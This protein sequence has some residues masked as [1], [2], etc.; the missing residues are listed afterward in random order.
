M[1]SDAALEMTPCE[2]DDPAWEKD[3]DKR[4][5]PTSERTSF[6]LTQRADASADADVRCILE[7]HQRIL[8]ILEIITFVRISSKAQRIRRLSSPGECASILTDD[9]SSNQCV[10]DLPKPT[11]NSLLLFSKPYYFL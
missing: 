6:C 9:H 11:I 4:D 5:I 2:L 10:D 8:L 3:S 7:Q 1:L